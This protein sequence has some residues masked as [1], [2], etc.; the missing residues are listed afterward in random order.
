MAAM[1]RRGYY[2]PSTQRT[3]TNRPR[4]SH[5]VGLCVAT[6]RS[7]LP[8]A[9]AHIISHAVIGSFIFI[10]YLLVSPCS[11]S[12]EP[13]N[14][15]HRELARP[16]TSRSLRDRRR[17]QRG[18]RAVQCVFTAARQPREPA[19]ANSCG[20][21]AATTPPPLPGAELHSLDCN[22][23]SWLQQ[24]WLETAFSTGKIGL[25]NNQRLR[26]PFP[27]FASARAAGEQSQT[28]QLPSL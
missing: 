12:D 16:L 18:E 19:I 21:R 25:L 24:S 23:G 28:P 10:C 5:P 15:A 9:A 11:T 27:K 26:I 14:A 22:Y 1:G 7:L 20:R 8:F 17:C 2:Q 6:T 13:E 3:H 4:Q